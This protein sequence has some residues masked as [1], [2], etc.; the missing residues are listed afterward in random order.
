MPSNLSP[1]RVPSRTFLLLAGSLLFGS[2]AVVATAP[3][4]AIVRAQNAGSKWLASGSAT[5]EIQIDGWAAP[6]SG[7]LYVLDAKPIAHGYGG[8]IWLVD[9]KSGKQMG[10]VI[11]GADPDFALSPDGKHLYVAARGNEESNLIAIDTARGT[12]LGQQTIE[13]RVVANGTPPYSTMSVSSDGSTL[14]VLVNSTNSSGDT[15]FQIASFDT[16]TGKLLPGH[17]H[18]GNCG[19]GRFLANA[20]P[21][22]FDFL[23]PTTNHVRRIRVDSSANEL[24]NSYVTFP[25]ERRSGIGQSLLSHDGQQLIIARGDGAIFTMD[26]KSGTFAATRIKGDIQG[27]TLPA[28]WPTSPDGSRLYVGYSRDPNKSF[29]LDFDRSASNSPRKQSVDELR[30]F[31]TKT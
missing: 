8:R 20:A 29:Y 19:Y 27:R 13:R 31:D 2:F 15:G 5:A 30:V 10:S 11:M 22:E 14:R 17:I 28:A 3:P 1:C 7:W 16:Q 12:I 6:Q 23:C 9:P 25:W 18:L 21:G 4:F 24:D 26:I